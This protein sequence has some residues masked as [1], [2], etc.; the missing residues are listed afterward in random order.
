MGEFLVAVR[1]D[2]AGHLRQC[3]CTL[4]FFMRGDGVTGEGTVHRLAV[5]NDAFDL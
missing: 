5:E 1:P 2:L 4:F 3:H